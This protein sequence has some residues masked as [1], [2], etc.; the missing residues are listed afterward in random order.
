MKNYYEVLNIELRA[1]EA[2]IKKAF[3][4]LAIKYHPDKNFGDNYFNDKFIEA[5]KAY[6]TLINPAL[7]EAYDVRLESF[8]N[9]Q[10]YTEKEKQEAYTETKKQAERAKEE[11][12]NYEPF[13]PFYSYRDRSQ[14]QT[15]QTDPIYDF[16]GIKLGEYLSFFKLPKNIGIIIGAYSDLLKGQ[17]PLSSSQK[18]LRVLKGLA[19]ALIIGGLIFLIGKPGPIWTVIW[20]IVPCLIALKLM[21]SSNKFIHTNFYIG[22]NGFAEYTC[23]GSTKNLSTNAE[24]NFN[25][26]TDLYVH[27]ISRSLNGVYQGTDFLYM[28]INVDTGNIPYSI[29]GRYDKNN[30]KEENPIELH[31]CRKVEQYWTIYLLDTMESKLEKDGYI[32]FNLYCHEQNL[33][34]KYIKLGVG[35]ITFIQSEND[36]FTYKFNEIKKMY[37]K[38]NDLYIEH[39]NFKKTFFFFKSGNAD[40]I[41]LLNL[42]NRGFFFKAMELLLGY[43]I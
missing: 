40:K 36:E 8:L 23:Y 17:E 5:K 11:K 15:P 25:D 35:Q 30:S 37:T 16:W 14:Q 19:I 18:A 42:C 29:D 13:N 22:V 21:V 33:Y 6:D 28:F 43:R 32:L 31:F 12:F 3:R 9:Q 38:G 4:K 10:S 20:F 39:L 41:P 26:I 24:V 1:S 2:E 27:E 7:K 34:S